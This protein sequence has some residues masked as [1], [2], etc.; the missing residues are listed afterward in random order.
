MLPMQRAR[1]PSPGGEHDPTGCNQDPAQP[2][3]RTEE[4]CHP[5]PLPHSSLTAAQ[6]HLQK[7][8]LRSQEAPGG[9]EEKVGRSDICPDPVHTAWNP[10]TAQ[11]LASAPRLDVGTRPDSSPARVPGPHSWLSE[12]YGG[13]QG[14]ACMRAHSLAVHLLGSQGR[15]PGCQKV[16]GPRG[17]ASLTP[18]GPA[19]SCPRTHVLPGGPQPSL[20]AAVSPV[21]REYGLRARPAPH[22]PILSTPT[23][24]G[25]GVPGEAGGRV[26][27]GG[28]SSCK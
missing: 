10:W 2:N 28:G 7:M 27:Q 1:V 15:A 22:S 6:L 19:W 3:E 12:D 23:R 25:L 11:G 16:T 17:Q 5:E 24:Q 26:A 21:P 18:R 20:P 8:T 4:A 13:P 9:S 14:G